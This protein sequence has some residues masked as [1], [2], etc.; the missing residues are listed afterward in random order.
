M[1]K[2]LLFVLTIIILMCSFTF[3]V[4]AEDEEINNDTLHKVLTGQIIEEPTIDKNTPKGKVTFI[5]QANKNRPADFYNYDFFVELSSDKLQFADATSNFYK[6]P[7]INDYTETYEFPYG[8]YEIVRGGVYDDVRNKFSIVTDIE[9]FVLDENNQEVTVIFNFENMNYISGE[10][11]T[12]NI[13]QNYTEETPNQFL[14]KYSELVKVV[15]I[16]MILLS[17]II[18]FCLFFLVSMKKYKK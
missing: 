8:E 1:K 4:H 16:L 5:V 18:M 12:E 11:E 17:V 2:S 10:K 13:I 3:M 14:G 15:G 6:I 9:K 7:E